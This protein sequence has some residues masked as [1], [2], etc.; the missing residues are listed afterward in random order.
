MAVA[1]AGG[2]LG[3]AELSTINLARELVD[4]EQVVVGEAGSADAASASG[5]LNLNRANA[6]ALEALPGIGPV[7]AERIVNDRESHGPFR[8]VDE[9]DRVSGVGPAVL[10]RMRPL[11]TV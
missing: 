1:A 3:E 7:L 10:E 6:A 9:L 2:A 8:T 5:L 4:G 11:L